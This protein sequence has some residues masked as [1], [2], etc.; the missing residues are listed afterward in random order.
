[1]V[2][3]KAVALKETGKRRQ[4][5]EIEILKSGVTRFFYAEQLPTV[6]IHFRHPVAD[7]RMES[8]ETDKI[9][10]NFCHIP[11]YF[12]KTKFSESKNIR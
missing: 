8:N 11:G 6:I 2:Q 4:R 3:E 9:N 7:Q 12:S 10:Q 5:I 1:V